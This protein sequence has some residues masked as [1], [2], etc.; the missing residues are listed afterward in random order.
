MKKKSINPL[1]I[2]LFLIIIGLV[3][4]IQFFSKKEE[5]SGI[6]LNKDIIN[7][8]VGG[9]ERLFIL[10]EDAIYGELVWKSENDLVATV[11]NGVVK[12]NKVGNTIIDLY[13]NDEI[14]DRC[15]VRVSE[16]KTDAIVTPNPP[17]EDLNGEDSIQEDQPKETPIVNYTVKY[18]GV[19]MVETGLRGVTLYGTD[20]IPSSSSNSLSLTPNTLY[21]VAF[22]YKTVR[23]T[24]KFNVD[25][26][27]DDLPEKILTATTT[28]QHFDWEVSSSSNNMKNSKL[29]FFDNQQEANEKDIIISNITMG[30]IR[31]D[32]KEPG[33]IIGSMPMPTRIGY[34]FLGWYTSPTGGTKVMPSTKVNS[35]MILFPHWE[36]KI[37]IITNEFI[38]P[39][40]YSLVSNA[41]YNS[42]TLKY[43]TIKSNENNR[44]Y[45]LI[46]VKDANKQINSAN[47]FLK[48]GQRQFLLNEEINS[49][50]LKFKGMIATN[51]SFTISSRSNTA[52]IATK[53]SI[54][55]N[56]KYSTK[57]VYGTLTI[58]SSGMLNHY[59]TKDATILSDWLRGVGARNTWA[60][61]HYETKNFNGGNI[62]GA[63]RRT[64]ICQI[65]KHNFILYAGYSTGIGDYMKE[66]HD[67]FGCKAVANLDGGGSSG[68]YYKTK[69]M[70]KV[71]VIY[72]YSRAGDSA[73]V[74][75]DMLYFTE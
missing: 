59:V 36:E 17:T 70:S 73:R 3:V 23:G 26:H 13:S 9:S 60:V 41:T 48:G 35:D 8:Y 4:Y 52:V 5:D 11:M 61:T 27:P 46:Y 19:N 50:N 1:I 34:N 22:D 69:G 40:G 44:Y 43:K 33:D 25:L 45:S 56:N 10:P 28:S 18:Y 64:A 31:R 68:M 6:R 30:T 54:I 58:D 71:G 12:G 74:I 38:I 55:I 21:V 57:Y 15:I 63:E 2:I 29:R 66:L 14:I 75:G 16:K 7:I 65:D 47:N 24:N 62:D 51:G 72:E 32:T 49:Q 20:S 39:R 42:D 37:R 67:I 53:G